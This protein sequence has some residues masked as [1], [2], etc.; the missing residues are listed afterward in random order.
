MKFKLI[1]TLCLFNGQIAAQ[2]EDKVF[3]CTVDTKCP[4][5]DQGDAQICATQKM[6]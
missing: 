5:T 6:S 2:N 4:D 1:S 3:S